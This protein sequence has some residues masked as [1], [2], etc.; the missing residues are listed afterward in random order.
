[1]GSRAFAARSAFIAITSVFLAACGTGIGDED[2]PP[3]AFS[4]EP[5]I[6]VGYAHSMI[7]Q[8]DGT[9]WTCGANTS[10]ELG[11]AFS[12]SFQKVAGGYPLQR[13]IHLHGR[14]HLRSPF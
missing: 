5:D 10:G 3:S 13:H 12:S 14:A 6:A 7:L 8:A 2:G 4:C 1:M 11:H 9:L